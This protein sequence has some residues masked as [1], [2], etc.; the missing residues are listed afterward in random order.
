MGPLPSE[1]YTEPTA[2]TGLLSPYLNAS[3]LPISHLGLR[4]MSLPF[5]FARTQKPYKFTT[6]L[7][8]L[9]TQLSWLR[10]AS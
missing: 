7:P 2:I 10:T 5:Q 8:H 4:Y 6:A 1:S 3:L 9:G